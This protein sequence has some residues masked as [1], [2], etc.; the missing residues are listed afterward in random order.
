MARVGVFVCWC[1]AN[2]AA[3]VD[4]ERV[5][6]AARHFPGVKFATDY[7]YMCSDPGQQKILEACKEH[8]LDG[9]VVAACSPRMHEPTFRQVAAEAGINPYRLQMANIREHC[10]WVHED[11]DEATAKAIDAVKMMVAR[12]AQSLPLEPVKVPVTRRALVIGGG[13]AGIQAAL[14]IAEGGVEVILVER[15][16]SIGGKM[17]GLDETFPTLDCSQCILTPKM[18]DA[19]RHPLIKLYTYCEVD[20]VDGAV[21]NFTVTIRKKAK[22]VN[23][24][25]CNG[26]GDCFRKCPYKKIPSEFDHGVGTRTA[27]YVPFPQAVPNKPVIDRENCVFFKTGKCKACEKTCQRGAIDFE[28]EDEFEEVR[29]G[30]IVVATGYDVME[31]AD[32][33]EFRYGAIPDVITGLQFER[34]SSASGPTEGKIVRPSNGEEPRT[35]VFVHCVGSRDENYKEYCSKICC[36]YNAKHAIILKHR[37]HDAEAYAFYIDVRAA[38]KGYEE[39]WKRACVEEGAQYLRGRVSRAYDEGGKVIVEG[40]DT[41]SGEQVEVAADL[42]VL[43]TAVIPAKGAAELARTLGISTDKDGFFNEAHPKLRPV[44]TA[45][46]GIF[47]AGCCQAPKDIPESVAQGSAAAAK[48]L[49]LLTKEE[50]TR[51]PTIAVVDPYICTGCWNCVNVCPFGA[52]EKSEIT[53]NIDGQRVTRAVSR[54]NEGKCEGCGLCVATCPGNCIDQRGFS[55]D[56]V[57]AELHGYLEYT[58][59]AERGE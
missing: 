25:L 38:G 35:V 30:G 9:L 19:A 28:Q 46:G 26:C 13:V 7:K 21:G 34:M 2:I 48:A 32:F 50:I 47:L 44:D 41:L 31:P 57:Y 36:M 40:E 16:P 52:P 6:E 17:A 18:V 55:D 56:Q 11:K 53:M 8:D 33:A 51:E 24:E 54:I 45:T 29:V 10:S 39:F 59:A 3:S 22:Y 23:H 14:D 5:A 20:K 27:I 15:S 37:I 4:V 1:G 12:V 58:K 49:G 42:V 43:A